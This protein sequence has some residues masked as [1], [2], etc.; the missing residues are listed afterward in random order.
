MTYFYAKHLQI[1]KII[2]LK[3]EFVTIRKSVCYNVAQQKV[4]NK[5]SK[6]R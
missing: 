3:N 5:T 4:L 2:R 1:K 6:G